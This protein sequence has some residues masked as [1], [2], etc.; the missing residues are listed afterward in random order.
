MCELQRRGK[1][2]WFSQELLCLQKG[3]LLLAELPKD[4]LEV[5]PQAAVSSEGLIGVQ[6]CASIA[7]EGTPLTSTSTR[8]GVVTLPCP[9][10]E[11]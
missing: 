6:R 10:W 9:R 2:R 7:T 4:P 8:H 11:Q 1:R 5:G 3:L